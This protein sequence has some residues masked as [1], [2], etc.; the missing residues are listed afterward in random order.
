MILTVCVCFHCEVIRGPE[1][2]EDEI[3]KYGGVNRRVHCGTPYPPCLDVRN[4]S[5]VCDCDNI[6]WIDPTTEISLIISDYPCSHPSHLCHTHLTQ[7]PDRL[8]NCGKQQY[9]YMYLEWL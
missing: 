7:L 9:I 8:S 1:V 2:I 3:R 5:L 6:W 4:N